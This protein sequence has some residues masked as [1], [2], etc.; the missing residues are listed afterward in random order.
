M[1]IAVMA[2]FS[3]SAN[4]IDLVGAFERAQNNDPSYQAAKAEKDAN[5]ANSIS[6]R[7][8]YLPALSWNQSQPSTTPYT[9]KST[10]MSQPI[11]DAAKGATVA[12]GG[13]QSTFA[14]RLFES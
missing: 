7:T 5:T 8:A 9:N 4:A 13:A 6:S 14:E 10:A 11:F 1:F 3:A 2:T 12:Q